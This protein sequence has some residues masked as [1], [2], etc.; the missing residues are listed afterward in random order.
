MATRVL[1][2][3]LGK[4]SL[5]EGAIGDDSAIFFDYLSRCDDDMVP[6]VI[7]AFG[8]GYVRAFERNA[9]C[10]NFSKGAYSEENRTAL[11]RALVEGLDRVLYEDRI[12]SEF[13]DGQPLR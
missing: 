6:F 3:D 4:L 11:D 12:A 2:Q 13:V 1:L 10:E 8:E 9:R 7:E 5:L